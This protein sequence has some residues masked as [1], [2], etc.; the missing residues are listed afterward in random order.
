MLIGII[1]LIISAIVVFNHHLIWLL[2]IFPG[3]YIAYAF[4]I[5][6]SKAPKLKDSIRLSHSE[7]E[8][9]QQHHAFFRFPFAVKS[10]STSL[11]LL[12]FISIILAISLAATGA[13]WGLA[14][15][16]G[17]FICGLPNPRFSP[18]TSILP[19]AQK[20]APWAIERVNAL[21]SL[22]KKLSQE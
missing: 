19:E 18:T 15:A 9:W 6:F 5:A 22:S 8:A 2:A 11:A 1:T 4:F 21:E 16:L 13:Y 3:L 17:W 12:Q 14:F 10:M 20:G 7:K